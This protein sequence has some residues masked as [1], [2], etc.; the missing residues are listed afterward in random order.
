M[1]T[2]DKDIENDPEEEVESTTPDESFSIK[3]KSS[4]DSGNSKKHRNC[5]LHGKNTHP[6]E[7]CKTIK[8]MVQKQKSDYRTPFAKSDSKPAFDKN[9]KKDWKKSA[10]DAKNKAKKDL[11][12]YGNDSD[13]DSKMSNRKRKAK[14]DSSS[15]SDSS[16][17]EAEVNLMDNLAA[18]NYSNMNA[19]IH[20]EH[21]SDDEKD[22]K[23]SSN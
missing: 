21:D 8:A 9:K 20:G 18:F 10:D 16:D 3:K 12:T 17:N 7:D 5:L 19:I 23:C 14:E 15:D 11:N 22:A 2:I 4:K 6:T 13:D 1:E